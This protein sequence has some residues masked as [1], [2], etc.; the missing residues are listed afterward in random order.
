MTKQTTAARHKEALQKIADLNLDLASNEALDPIKAMPRM[1]EI[2]KQALTEPEN[3]FEKKTKE[4]ADFIMSNI[5]LSWASNEAV[6]EA[7]NANGISSVTG[8]PW[9]KSNVAKIVPAAREI[10]A[11][12]M[13]GN[14][15][16]VK[17]IGEVSKVA[18][19]TSH[20]PN[21]IPLQETTSPEPE[22]ESQISSPVEEDSAPQEEVAAVSAEDELMREL[23]EIEELAI[24]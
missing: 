4:V 8:K 23:A 19:E 18:Q 7:L 24:S 14:D 3:Q 11:G 16:G 10:I 9:T 15:Q 20:L 2:A 21:E 13:T 6:C 12:R 22:V 17:E 1:V 5:A